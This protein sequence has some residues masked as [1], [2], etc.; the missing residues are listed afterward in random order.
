MD[1]HTWERIQEIYHLALTLPPRSGMTLLSVPVNPIQFS[2][3]K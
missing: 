3:K 1:P 2:S